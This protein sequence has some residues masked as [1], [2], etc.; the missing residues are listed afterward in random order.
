MEAFKNTDNMRLRI[1][2]I[3]TIYL[4]IILFQFSGSFAFAQ[5][6][7]TVRATHPKFYIGIAGGPSISREIN[8][9]ILS[10]SGLTSVDKNTF[11]GSLEMGY[12]FSKSFGLSTGI[13]YFSYN[14]ELSLKSY[15]NKFT[16]TDSENEI[17]ERRVSGANIKEIRNIIF[18]KIPL[19]LN[20][21]F[22]FG[23]RFGM[24]IQAGANMALTSV[25]EYTGSGTFSYVGYYPAFNVIF[26][27]L[28]EYGFPGN[29][30]IS[31]KGQLTL[32]ATNFEVLTGAGF[33]C[34]VSKKIQVI[35]GATYTRSLSTI[36][37][38]T[39]PDEFQLST[40][41]DDLNSLMGAA[42]NVTAQLMGLKLGIRYYLK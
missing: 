12:F 32:K 36:S 8:S 35:L 26:Q 20:L 39:V 16:A 27:N 7:D 28:P 40:N 13:E 23:K 21:Q 34:F 10:I 24:Y 14:S 38:Y 31:K 17:Y 3:R 33:Q 15:K 29:V 41:T 42:S 25:N 18:L 1:T 2:N 9:T 5:E 37:G 11:S 22:F 4:L 19:C 6:S 30:P